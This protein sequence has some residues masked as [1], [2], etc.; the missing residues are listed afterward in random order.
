MP[1]KEIDLVLLHTGNLAKSTLEAYHNLS[2]SYNLLDIDIQMDESLVIEFHAYYR[3][4]LAKIHV[5]TLTQ[6]DRVVMMDSDGLPLRNLDHLFDTPMG[7]PIAGAQMYW[8]NKEW[9]TSAFLVVEPSLEVFDVLKAKVKE[10]PSEPTNLDMD[11]LNV[12]MRGRSKLLDPEYC[13][14]NSHW[15]TH[16][17]IAL[18][19]DNLVDLYEKRCYYMHYTAV[20][21]PWSYRSKLRNNNGG[22]HV[23]L[24]EQFEMW[25]FVARDKCSVS[26]LKTLNP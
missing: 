14:L 4:C 24:K 6:Y 25:E 13:C 17:A 20:G 12:V 9:F 1:S 23:L 7:T 10:N 2:S 15:E 18:G 26:Y 5:F 11:L 21:K 8:G 16:E 3:L 22:F 19:T